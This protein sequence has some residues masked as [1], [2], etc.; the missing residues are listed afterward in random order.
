MSIITLNKNID[1]NDNNNNIAI[2]IRNPIKIV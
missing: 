2:I 1:D